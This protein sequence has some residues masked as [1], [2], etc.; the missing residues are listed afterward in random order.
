MRVEYAVGRKTGAGS[1]FGSEGSFNGDDTV[2]T[3][4]NGLLGWCADI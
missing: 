1:N 3:G 2:G 4:S